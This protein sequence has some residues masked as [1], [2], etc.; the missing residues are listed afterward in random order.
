MFFGRHCTSYFLKSLDSLQAL[1]VKQPAQRP[2]PEGSGE[3]FALRPELVGP[4]NHGTA[5]Q[6]DTTQ[7][8]TTRR[9]ATQRNNAS[10]QLN[11][12]P[13][14]AVPCRAMQFNLNAPRK[15]ATR[16]NKIQCNSPCLLPQVTPQF[17]WPKATPGSLLPEYHDRLLTSDDEDPLTWLLYAI[18]K[19]YGRC[20]GR[21]ACVHTTH[22]SAHISRRWVL[23][24]AAGAAR[25]W[26][27][28]R[29][30]GCVWPAS[31][32][33]IDGACGQW[34]RICCCRCTPCPEAPS[35]RRKLA[36]QPT[37][38]MPGWHASGLC[39]D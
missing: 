6:R 4:C 8:D 25:L 39:M 15:N 31:L 13:C 27:C 33:L 17:K 16:D 21:G 9:D 22:T 20:G 34:L 11:G 14:H 30:R 35:G 18:L 24:N 23:I 38:D 1:S 36:G 7:C 32:R 5:Q 12:T 26:R 10:R 3:T 29:D 37:D 28:G 2:R 19:V